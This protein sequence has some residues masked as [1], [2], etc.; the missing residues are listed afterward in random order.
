MTTTAAVVM[1]ETKKP[2]THDVDEAFERFKQA[3]SD[4]LK[5]TPDGQEAWAASSEDFNIGDFLNLRVHT[6]ADFDL[7][8]LNQGIK[9]RRAEGLG[10]DKRVNYDHVLYNEPTPIEFLCRQTGTKEQD[11]EVIDGP[12]SGT[13]EDHWYRHKNGDEAYVNDD[14]GHLTAEVNKP[15]QSQ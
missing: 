1:V 12:E 11:W 8:C 3:V 5:D 15:E 13:G 4:W 7:K 2:E 10:T 14:Q 6:L 9:V